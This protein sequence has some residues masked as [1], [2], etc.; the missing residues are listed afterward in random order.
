MKT[1]PILDLHPHAD[2]FEA[3]VRRGLSQPRKT[4]PTKFLYD[5]QGSAL[6]EQITEL[7]EYYPTRTELAILRAYLPEIAALV[8][9]EALVLEFGSGSGL[10]TR[11][12]LQHLDR[13]IAYVPV[14]ISRAA[15]ADSGQALSREFPGLEVLPVLAD[16]SQ[17][18]RLPMHSQEE[19]KRLVFFPGSTIGNFTPDDAAHFLGRCSKLCGPG[20]GLLVG[21][22]L[23]KSADILEPAYDDAAGVTAAFNLNL[24][25]RVNRE[26]GGTFDLEAF[27]HRAIYDQEAGR[28]EMHL[29]SQ[30]A[31]TVSLGE[32]RYA[33]E[34]GESILTEYSHKYTLEGFAALAARGGWAV[35]QVWTD[36]EQLF[37]VQYLEVPGA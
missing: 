24:L 23:Q 6:F 21:T 20:G 31:Q 14:D 37:S 9:P 36:P 18:L 2:D 17:R 22:D 1:V 26:L 3:E 16:F 28:I 25:T 4:L 12:L 15:L 35:K 19:Q 5:R 13:P 29:V 34:E 7:P 8:G 11:L 32:A 33:F 30:K 10:K 27:T